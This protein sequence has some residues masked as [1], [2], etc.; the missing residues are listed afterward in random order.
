MVSE[1]VGQILNAPVANKAIDSIV[2]SNKGALLCKLVIE[3][4]YDHMD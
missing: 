1:S 3:K 2:R 4:V